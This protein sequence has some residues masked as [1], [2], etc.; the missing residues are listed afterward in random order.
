MPVSYI[1]KIYLNP[2]KEIPTTTLVS[3]LSI[4]SLELLIN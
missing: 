1:K 2:F 3:T 4:L